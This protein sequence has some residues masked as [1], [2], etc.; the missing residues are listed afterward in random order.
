[1]RQ[2][3]VLP[4]DCPQAGRLSGRGHPPDILPR[5]V[6]DACLRERCHVGVAGERRAQHRHD[7]G[8]ARS[9]AETHAE[10]EEGGELEFTQQ[11]PVRRLGR[12]MRCQGMIERIAAQLRQRRDRRGAD[13]AVEQHR[14]PALARRQRRAQD[15]GKFAP[16]E[17]RRARQR[18]GEAC[19]V[20]GKRTSST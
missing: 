14:D 7:Q 4:R 2:R 11:H 12:D 9:L 19:S 18:V 15:G 8:S 20:S 1:M 10:I 6:G 16:A 3:H 17:R 5:S 13:E